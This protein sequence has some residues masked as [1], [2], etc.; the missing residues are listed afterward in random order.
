M[1]NRKLQVMTADFEEALTLHKAGHLAAAQALYEQVLASNSAD[2]DLLN[3]LGI[4]AQ[5]MGRLEASLSYFDRSLTI[6]S[7][8]PAV[9]VNRGQTLQKLGRNAQALASYEQALQLDNEDGAT[10]FHQGVALHFLK[11]YEQAL[12]SYNKAIALGFENSA[13]YNN[14]GLI[15]KAIKL[16]NDALRCFERAIGLEPEF[17]EA[18]LNLGHLFNDQNRLEQANDCFNTA[19]AIDHDLPYVKGIIFHNKMRMCDWSFFERDAQQILDAVD[20][21]ERA[22]PPFPLMAFTDSLPHLRKAAEIWGRD[23][24]NLQETLPPIALNPE[25]TKIRVGYF[26]SDFHDHATSYLMIEEFENTDKSLFEI[27]AFS[28]GPQK[29]DAMR[30]RLVNAFDHF[31]DVSELTDLEIA[32]LARDHEIDLAIDLKGFT[33]DCRPGI[34]ALRAAPIQINYLGYPGTMACDYMDY[35]IADEVVIPKESQHHYSEQ[36]LYMQGC[37]QLSQRERKVAKKLPTRSEVGLPETGFV[38]CCFNNSYKITPSMFECWMQILHATPGSVLW[39]LEDNAIASSNLR[40]EAQAQGI[41]PKRVVFAPRVTNEE[42]LLR[43][44]LA[45]LFIDTFPYSAHT[46]ASD[47]IHMKLPIVTIQGESFASRVASSLIQ[48]NRC[49]PIMISNNFQ[50]YFDLITN[51]FTIE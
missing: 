36:I 35:L 39:L 5:Q 13:L 9:H 51:N 16:Y 22:S 7:K 37:Y 49:T 20:K 21:G 15:F 34:F 31:V 25:H 6:D 17:V 41:D 44:Q 29:Y 38:Y 1:K 32:Q 8:T 28:F 48:L 2:V 14:C 27:F 42:H 12:K 4:L 47:A 30:E 10:Y 45:D 40:L 26:S 3:L 33:Q 18:H 50:S 43:H 19:L 46:T 24:I 23:K 11:N